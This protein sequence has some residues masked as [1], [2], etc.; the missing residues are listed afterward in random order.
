MSYQLFITAIQVNDYTGASVL[1]NGL[2][3]ADWFL[4]DIG[5]DAD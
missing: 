4:A 5:Y 1:M 3:E 2:P